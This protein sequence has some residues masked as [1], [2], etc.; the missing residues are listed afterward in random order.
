[1]DRSSIAIFLAGLFFGG[2][3]D[4][5]IL[6]VMHQTVTPYGVSVGVA[7]NWGMAALDVALTIGL[8]LIGQRAQRRV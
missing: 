4:H 6:A 1:M 2:A 7:G 3:I 5:V 8:I